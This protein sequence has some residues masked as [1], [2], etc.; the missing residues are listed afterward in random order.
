MSVVRFPTSYVLMKRQQE[1]AERA[2]K[3]FL[4]ND[5]EHYVAYSMQVEELEL[6]IRRMAGLEK[7]EAR[8]QS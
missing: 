3:A 6:Q 1:I 4:D 7:L 5:L 8:K 2:T